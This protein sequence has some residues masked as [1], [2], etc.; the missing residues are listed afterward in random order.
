[1]LYRVSFYEIEFCE[2]GIKWTLSFIQ[3]PWQ[4]HLKSKLT[5]HK[6]VIPEIIDICT[7]KK[8]KSKI[9]YRTHQSTKISMVIELD[10]MCSKINGDHC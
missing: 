7:Y 9:G 10:N 8:K 6:Y 5:A 4:R 2:G 1:M 3:F